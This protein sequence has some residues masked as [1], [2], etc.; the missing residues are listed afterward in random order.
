MP[1][2]YM[3]ICLHENIFGSLSCQVRVEAWLCRVMELTEV[4]LPAAL[5]LGCLWLV[6]TS[7]TPFNEATNPSD[8][9]DKIWNSPDTPSIPLLW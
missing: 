3:L 1:K 4:I 7:T 5:D 8:S 9:D 6:I 2:I